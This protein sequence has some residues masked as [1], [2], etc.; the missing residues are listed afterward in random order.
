MVQ[1]PKTVLA[2]LPRGKPIA[3]RS[4]A[5]IRSVAAPLHWEFFSVD[6]E[7][8]DDGDVRI[9]R[10]PLGV[11]SIQALASMF[12]PDG[13][14]VWSGT[15]L[16]AEVRAVFGYRLPIVSI[17]GGH[18]W[19]G[20]VCVDGDSASIAELA[21]R[22]L[23]LTERDDFAYVPY[24]GGDTWN[25]GR[26]REF[27]RRIAIAGKRFHRFPGVSGISDDAGKS[28]SADLS[29]WLNELPKPCGI[30]A[31]NDIAGERVLGA[32][33]GLGLRVPQDVA[34]VGVD[35]T[36]YICE[37]AMPTLSSVAQDIYGE[38]REAAR[39]L[40]EWIGHPRRRPPA[41]LTVPAA[42]LVRRASSRMVYDDRVARALEAI[43]L[44]ACEVGFGPPDVVRA[45]CLSRAPAFRL[46]KRVTG[47]TILEEIHAVR[48]ARA[49]S[50][51]ATGTAPGIVAEKC[52]YA[53]HED[54]RRVFR[55]RI[56]ETVRNWTLACNKVGGD[57]RAPRSVTMEGRAHAGIA[58]RSARRSLPTMK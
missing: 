37:N 38:G 46:F 47:R 49:K 35:D 3:Q 33:A 42:R 1:S 13:L 4:L 58:L 53:S 20:A 18:A 41:S 8:G 50:L 45:L 15:L 40:A 12:R 25:T 17:E 5:G 36:E 23:L 48:L 28:A 54:F 11:D 2:V 51:L 55:N 22:E 16:P 9:G 43:R 6:C 39:L 31:A 56:G 24:A 52:G 10:S 14:I 57:L 26:G 30:F 19:R 7:R 34:V 44:H 21:A 29:G 27:A 32:C